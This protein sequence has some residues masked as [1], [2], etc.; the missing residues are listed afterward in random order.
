MKKYQKIAK[1]ANLGIFW[2]HVPKRCA[3][4]YNFSAHHTNIIVIF[5]NFFGVQNNMRAL[6]FSTTITFF[7]FFAKIW[8]FQIPQT[9]NNFEPGSRNLKIFK[10]YAHFLIFLKGLKIAIK[11]GGPYFLMQKF[12][13][14]PF[15]PYKHKKVCEDIRH[16]PILPY[17]CKKVILWKYLN[18]R[19][20]DV[21]AWFTA[22]ICFFSNFHFFYFFIFW[23]NWKSHK[24]T[25]KW[26]LSMQLIVLAYTALEARIW[27]FQVYRTLDGKNLAFE[28]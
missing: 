17:T 13:T 20:F 14:G 11:I 21:L 1:N 19:K 2:F 10:K 6:L 7:L 27:K 16:P 26:F 12:P 23:K 15:V 8:F 3:H 4:A 24:M 22:K 18:F 9:K 28:W 5:F 25:I